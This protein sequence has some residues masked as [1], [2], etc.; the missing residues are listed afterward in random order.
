MDYGFARGVTAPCFTAK[1]MNAFAAALGNSNPR[2]SNGGARS[3]TKTD[4]VRCPKRGRPTAAALHRT[5]RQPR[6]QTY[7]TGKVAYA[8]PT[9]VT[10]ISAPIVAGLG[11][12]GTPEACAHAMAAWSSGTHCAGTTVSTSPTAT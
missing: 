4:T 11:G 9:L 10:T 7:G 3:A 1:S 12:A 8:R 6:H 2:P 5:S